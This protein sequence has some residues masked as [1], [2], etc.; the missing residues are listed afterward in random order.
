MSAIQQGRRALFPIL[1]ML[2]AVGAP[3]YA[4][5][6]L[7]LDEVRERALA[8]SED[9]AIARHGVE[10]AEH[11][12]ASA[13]AQRLPGLALSAG[14]THVSETAGIDLALPGLPARRISFGDGNNFE[15]A[16]TASVPL[17]T[18][19]RLSHLEEA[20]R[21][22]A[23]V[24]AEA[25]RARRIDVAYRATLL[26]RKAQLARKWMDIY[27][28]QLR[29]LE[30]QRHTLGAL[31]EQGQILAYD[32][33]VLSTRMAA[34]RVQAAGSASDYRNTVLTLAALIGSDAPFDVT[35]DAAVDDDFARQGEAALLARALEQRPDL[36]LHERQAGMYREL[37]DAD[38]AAW[39]PSVNGMVSLRYGIPGVDQVANAWMGY[40]VAGVNLQWNVWNWG[41][42]RH[43]VE[44]RMLDADNS[45]LRAAQLRR[46]LASGVA[47][48]LNE[49]E[50]LR[51]SMRLLDAQI[52][53]ERE[54]QQLLAVRLAEGLAT[55]TELVDAEVS[56]TT[57][58][59]SREQ[60][61][62]QYAMKIAELA[63][64]I[65]RE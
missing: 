14:Y 1:A 61:T 36:R 51:G 34:L 46:Q 33:L 65:G 25:L 20:Q 37:A 32:T 38:R 5:R 10:Q 64:T 40:Y 57:A 2:L 26:Y 44:A 54:K 52:A 56:L 63:A 45:A 53:Q 12:H 35:R 59:I 6:T 41:A 8:H 22:G 42:D 4:Q 11:L 28:E 58:R 16:L 15:S 9:V 48:L 30:Q 19:F 47:S 49:L 27:D 13:R 62:L 24:A 29:Y 7:S 43:K 23:E 18:G 55:A 31:L 50:V 17:F 21:Q 39:L 60:I 3:G